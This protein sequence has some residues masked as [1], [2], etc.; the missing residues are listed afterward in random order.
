MNRKL[1]IALSLLVLLG[2]SLVPQTLAQAR[3]PGVAEGNYFAYTIT[4]SWSSINL[5]ATVPSDLLAINGTV[6]NCTVLDVVSSNVTTTDIRT[7]VNGT[8]ETAFVIQDVDSGASFVQTRLI[9]IVGANLGV[10][11]MLHSSEDDP[12]R[13]NQTVSIDYGSHKRDANA[14]FFSSP[15]TDSSNN[16]VGSWTEGYYFDKA[17]GILVAQVEKSVDSG[18]NVSII[19][20]LVKTNLWSITVPPSIVS[21]TPS[22]PA[23]D[24]VQV[25]GITLPIILLVVIIAVVIVAA[26][27]LLVIYKKRRNRK[28]K[29]RR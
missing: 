28:R 16:T 10:N 14:V 1:T 4:T 19:I 23:S 17:T 13:I 21:P 3:V 22:P 5:G 7:Y 24:T 9:E 2:F 11:D 15:I 25:F 6:H 26:V 12:R 27:A 18:E 20:G 8:E 29:H